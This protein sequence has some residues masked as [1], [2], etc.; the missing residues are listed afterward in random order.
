[1]KTKFFYN[2]ADKMLAQIA[3]GGGGCTIHGD[4]QSQAGCGSGQSDLVEDVPAH[5]R[6]DG[7]MTIYFIF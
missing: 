5:C 2:E 6:G 1:M 7:L 4:I 3:Q